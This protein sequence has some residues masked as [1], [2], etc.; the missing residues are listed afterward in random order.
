MT[1]F[2]EA[3]P[4]D[5]PVFVSLDKELFPYS[6]WS[7]A[8]YKQEFAEMPRTRYFIVALDQ[9]QSIIGYAG[10]LVPAPEVEADVLTIGVVPAHRGKGIARQLMSRITDFAIDRQ[11]SAMMLEV[12][13]DNTEAIGLYES[14]GYLKISIR[15]D[16]FGSGLDALIMRKDLA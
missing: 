2:R 14:L 15:K 3:M 4:L 11:A 7:A 5:I 12:K 6:P 16:Y 13:S 10:I 1:T 9:D 8:Q